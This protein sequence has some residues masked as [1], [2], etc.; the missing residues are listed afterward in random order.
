MYIF[1]IFLKILYFKF[2]G[3]YIKLKR[4]W[5]DLKNDTMLKSIEILK[6]KYATLVEWSSLLNWK[7]RSRNSVSYTLKT[8]RYNNI[9]ADDKCS[10]EP[11]QNNATCV[12]NGYTVYQCECTKGW[13][14]KHCEVGKSRIGWTKKR[15]TE[16]KYNTKRQ[17]REN[18]AQVHRHV[19]IVSILSIRWYFFFEKKSWLIQMS[20]NVQSIHAATME[21]ALTLMETT[22]A[23]VNQDGRLKIVPMVI[24]KIFFL[25]LL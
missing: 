8:R 19:Y 22:F 25:E 7:W 23:Y 17:K 5:T 2:R 14:G 10:E 16:K 24:K 21:D 13:K 15:P 4:T 12:S 20:M 3:M 9:F 1:F 18:G 11:C 6:L